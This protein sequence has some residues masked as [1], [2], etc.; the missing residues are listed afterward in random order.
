MKL[1]KNLVSN[2]VLINKIIKKI[3]IISIKENPNKTRIRTKKELEVRKNEFLKICNLL[4]KLKIKY[5]L[6]AGTLLGAVRNKSF[7]PWDW[8]VELSV[9]SHEVENKMDQLI[10]EIKNSGFTINKYS[11]EL[12][13]L[14]IDFIGQFSKET[15]SYTIQGWSY[16]KKK[17]IY[18]RNKFVVPENLIKNMKK[19]KFYNK[20]HYA[21]Y[22]PEDYL[23]YQYGDWKKPIKT[24]DKSVYLTRNFS[25]ISLMET[26]IKKIIK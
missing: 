10:S 12:S 14:K 6:A 3:Q 17:K 21:P 20:Y 25:G 26:F 19:I 24:S 16:N 8:D 18:W 15:T 2:F 1:K 5:F 13:K 22:P 7:I 11:K 4:D 9:Y 23:K